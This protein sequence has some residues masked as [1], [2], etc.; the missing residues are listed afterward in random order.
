MNVNLFYSFISLVIVIFKELLYSNQCWYFFYLFLETKKNFSFL[1]SL[2]IYS[3]QK[4][5]LKVMLFIHSHGHLFSVTEQ[6]MSCL[7][8]LKVS[9]MKK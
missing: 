6:L 7:R 8:N 2:H 5:K 1:T 4:C 3:V 9:V